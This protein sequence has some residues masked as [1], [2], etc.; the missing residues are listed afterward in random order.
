M[1]DHMKF[2]KYIKF[3]IIFIFFIITI[4]ISSLDAQVGGQRA[5][6][7]LESAGISG[8]KVE[9]YTDEQMPQV[10]QRVA[11][12]KVRYARN[13]IHNDLVY[14]DRQ[15]QFY[16]KSGIK[17]VLNLASMGTSPVQGIDRLKNS[18]PT[19]EML[20][21]IEGL[22]EPVGT[23]G[24]E[25]TDFFSHQ[26]ELYDLVKSDPL[27]NR[28]PVIGLSLAHRPHYALLGDMSGISD[29]GNLHSYPTVNLHPGGGMLENWITAADE[30]SHQGQQYWCT[31]AGYHDNVSLGGTP[32]DV[33]AKYLPR[34]ILYYFMHPRVEKLFYYR[35]VDQ[36][37]DNDSKWWGICRNDATVS[38][39][40]AYTA[41]KN[42]NSILDDH[43]A[44]FSPGFL[45]FTLSG[46]LTGIKHLLLQKGDGT[47]YLVIWQEV[48]NW[49]SATGEVTYNDRPLLLDIGGVASE[50][51]TYLPSFSTGVWP[52]E[53]YGSTP[54]DTFRMVS[55]ISINVPDHI[56]II[57]ISGMA[58]KAGG[59]GS[60]M[61]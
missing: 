42:M 49:S 50:I 14:I 31:E 39:K 15:H 12:L 20:Y 8:L 52:Y 33:H 60:C 36:E 58:D 10:M 54:K 45:N 44:T 18:Y 41:W 2:L 55:N 3:K 5:N 22:N 51:K 25:G 61:P 16:K 13:R 17:W 46:D 57:E 19:L 6:D 59:S 47:F 35:L 1:I 9:R 24:Y 30:D 7:F 23:P 48:N 11:D 32:P 27:L 56:M 4:C 26:K 29:F 43:D 38:P 21:A 37:M 28:F 53:G 34:L 40:P